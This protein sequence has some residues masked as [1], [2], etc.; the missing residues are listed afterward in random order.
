[1][2]TQP[3]PPR[4]MKKKWKK[5]IEKNLIAKTGFE[6]VKHRLWWDK[7]VGWTLTWWEGDKNEGKET[8]G[9]ESYTI[10]KAHNGRDA[11]RGRHRGDHRMY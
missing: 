2:E 9:K 11:D 6:K 4:K 1:M 5:Q 3:D 7:S 8:S 10:S